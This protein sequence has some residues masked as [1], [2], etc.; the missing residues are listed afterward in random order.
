ML[1]PLNKAIYLCKDNSVEP[2]MYNTWHEKNTGFSQTRV[3]DAGWKTAG[4]VGLYAPLP[5]L[6]SKT[7]AYLQRT[8]TK[9]GF[10][11]IMDEYEESDGYQWIGFDT[12]TGIS[13]TWRFQTDGSVWNANCYVPTS[14]STGSGGKVY[15]FSH[16]TAGLTF[17]GAES[18]YLEIPTNVST[19]TI[20]VDASGSGYD[21]WHYRNVRQR[22]KVFDTREPSQVGMAPMAFGVYKA[23]DTVSFSV[24]YDEIVNNRGN[25]T[26]GSVSGMPLSNVT[27]TS[28]IGTS[29]LHFTATAASDFE[30]T[31]NFNDTLINTKPMNGTVYDMA[32]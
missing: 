13:D 24:V 18:G 19:I 30:I 29:V 6:S 17:N 4:T 22:C 14:G 23:G 9:V 27:Y 16:Q 8:A 25:A 31:P 11:L 1:I 32:G 3:T 12:N 2:A 7:A 28:G 10:G 21:D 20:K 15:D 5:Q 26:F